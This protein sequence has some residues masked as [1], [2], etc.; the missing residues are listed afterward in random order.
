[1]NALGSG[2]GNAD[3]EL[4][5]SGK[6]ASNVTVTSGG[7]EL[8]VNMQSS[9]VG[10]VAVE[11]VGQPGFSLAD[12]DKLKGGAIDAVASWGGGETASLSALAGKQV[13]LNV[14]LADAKL[15]SLRLGCAKP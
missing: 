7:V 1:M 4:C 8:Y 12:A 11:V 3:A 9:V 2:T 5:W 13:Q 15:Y 6:S 14:A 10:W